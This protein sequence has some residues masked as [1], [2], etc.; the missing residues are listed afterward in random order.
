MTASSSSKAESLVR[1]LRERIV[2]LDGAMGTMIQ[3]QRLSEA[4]F[5]GE[6][7]RAHPRD[8]KGNN[9]PLALTQPDLLE[10]THRQYLEAGADIVET[11]TFNSNAVSLAD[12]GMESLVYEINVAAAGV[13]PR[14]GGAGG[15]RG[16]G[17]PRGGGGRGPPP[18]PPPP[19]P[20]RR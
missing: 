10:S 2:V 18:P 6:R 9:A 4:D 14:G 17:P 8:V 5:R 7:S 13:A 12:Y 16:E 1:L 11:N 15:A 19:A 20:R 3:A